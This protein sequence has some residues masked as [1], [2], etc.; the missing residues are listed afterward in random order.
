MNKKLKKVVY[1]FKLFSFTTHKS[2]YYEY[3]QSNITK[4]N[5]E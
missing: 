4:A 3:Y 1:S 5:Q 2:K